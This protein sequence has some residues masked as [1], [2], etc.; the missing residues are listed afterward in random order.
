MNKGRIHERELITKFVER[1]SQWQRLKYEIMKWPEDESNGE[2][3]ALAGSECSK[4]L[5]IEHTLIEP[6][7]GRKLDDERFLRILE[8]LEQELARTFDCDLIISVEVFAIQKGQ[9]WKAIQNLIREW[10]LK[11]VPKLDMG[12]TVVT[13]PSV[14]FALTLSKDA[15]PIGRVLVARNSRPD[16]EVVELIT[17]GIERKKG[18]LNRHHDQGHEAIL[19][20]ESDDIALSHIDF[21]KAF[22]KS[23]PAVQHNIDQIWYAHSGT[24][25]GEEM[26]YW[27]WCFLGPHQII[28][29][30]NPP[31]HMIGPRHAE[32]WAVLIADDK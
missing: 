20:L 1:Y 16:F 18:K 7:K 6:F 13:I 22:L 3:E 11:N 24:F 5:A 28:D 21:Y 23:L 19:I 14:P 31:H 9:N 8:P 25:K 32:Y 10:L 4:I 17:R 2:V 15:E 27:F 29:V 30:A 12:T 26:N